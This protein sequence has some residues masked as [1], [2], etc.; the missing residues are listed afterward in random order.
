MIPQHLRQFFW[1]VDADHLDL[2]K[3]RDYVIGR[4]LELGTD[5]AVSWMRA[6]FQ[7]EEITKVIREDH[8]LSPKS[9]TYWA[10]LYGIP[11]EQV[12]AL[13]HTPAAR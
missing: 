2:Q 7:D 5:E 9:A 6:S 4:I 12:A 13:S 3:Y 11:T 1:E 10:L 8:R